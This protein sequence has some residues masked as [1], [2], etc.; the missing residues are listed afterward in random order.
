[1]GFAV[2]G[3]ASFSGSGLGP[4]HAQMTRIPLKSS[5]RGFSSGVSSVFCFLAWQEIESSLSERWSLGLR[6]G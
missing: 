5:H 1:M 4:N 2:V 3:L 6:H